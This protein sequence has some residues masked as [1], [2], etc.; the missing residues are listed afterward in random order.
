MKMGILAAIVAVA[1]LLLLFVP[2]LRGYFSQRRAA[3]QLPQ[4][5]EQ[6]GLRFEPNP[7]P[8]LLGRV[9]GSFGGRRVSIRPDNFG[10]IRLPFE[11]ELPV[12]VASAS[13][14][15]EEAP[16]LPS[17]D[18]GDSRFD[19]AFPVRRGAEVAA[20]RLRSDEDLR[21]AL[22]DFA[23]RWGG[24]L[25]TVT[26]APGDLSV[27]HEGGN[28]RMHYAIPA[29]QLEEI[30]RELVSIADRAEQTLR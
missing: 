23:G 26:L 28:F 8:D 19:R 13:W 9:S 5:A 29:D 6:L 17:F 24:T 12:F 30:L 2:Y 7:S 21:R 10:L 11:Q 1:L 25:G 14:P 15:V 18:T 20:D 4:V 3:D 16:D 22:A 27:R